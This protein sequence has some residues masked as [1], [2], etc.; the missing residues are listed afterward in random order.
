MLIPWLELPGA[1][2]LIGAFGELAGLDLI[3]LGTTAD[4]AEIK[5]TAVTQPLIV[6][7]GLLA[8]AQ[9]DL[10]DNMVVAGHSVGEITAAA[11]AGVLEPAAAVAFAARRGAEMAAACALSPSGM[12]AV[13]GGD[14]DEVSAA[15][16]A[17]GLTPANRNG[18]GQI[19]A[20][21]SLDALAALAADPPHGAR[22]RPLPVAGA[23]HTHFMEA[24]EQALDEFSQTVSARDPHHVLLSNADGAATATGP[25]VL[26]RLVAQMT[27][28]VRWDLCQQ[29][30]RDLGI[31]AVLELPPAGT[32]AALAKRELPGIDILA[33]KKPADLVAAQQLLDARSHD[34]RDEHRPAFGVAVSPGGGVF[35]RA[36]GM[37]AGSSVAPGTR[38]ATIAT[39]RDEF[40]VLAPLSRRMDGLRLAEWLAHDG[41]VVSAGLAVA[42]LKP[43]R[44]A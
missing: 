38:I 40:P 12:S 28:P 10:A 8:A 37:N 13:L 36:E 23:F 15:I 22:I 6:A 5:D 29:A 20:A 3:R 35:S 1:D 17:K 7:L 24:A 14:P 34:G 18:A 30:I 4:A 25:G 31:T 26:A 9:L 16:A 43:A 19:V 41:D 11:I 2:E 33:L 44:E 27:L 39:A 42:R 21:G 32:L